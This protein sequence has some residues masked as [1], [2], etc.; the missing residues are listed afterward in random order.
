MAR[1][2]VCAQ[3]LPALPASVPTPPAIRGRWATPLTQAT[4]NPE[5]LETTRN[6][7]RRQ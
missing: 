7:P 5:A 1:D 3:D 2:T 6:E 4:S